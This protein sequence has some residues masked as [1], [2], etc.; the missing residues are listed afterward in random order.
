MHSYK[1]YKASAEAWRRIQQD[2]GAETIRGA[3]NALVN[4][5]ITEAEA[6]EVYGISRW[7]L[8]RACRVYD[9]QLPDGRL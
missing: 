2:T 5:R 6:C 9:L 7:A 4:R 8:R 1:P 3:L